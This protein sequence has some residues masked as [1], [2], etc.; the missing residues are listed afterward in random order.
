MFSAF[1]EI[2]LGIPVCRRK[3][4]VT[5][6]CSKKPFNSN[7]APRGVFQNRD[8]CLHVRLRWPLPCSFF[9]D[10]PSF[11]AN[12][13]SYVNFHPSHSEWYYEIKMTKLTAFR[14]RFGVNLNFTDVTSMLREEKWKG[15][16]RKMN[17]IGVYRERRDV[18]IIHN[19]WAEDF[20]AFVENF[21]SAERYVEKVR[22]NCKS[23]CFL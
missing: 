14:W 4:R 11:L 20:Y 21:Y 22:W 2:F 9:P 8:S 18:W 23:N 5:G 17:W 10:V 1:N 15:P 3:Y 6:F 13:L 19:N 16:R 7:F 12:F